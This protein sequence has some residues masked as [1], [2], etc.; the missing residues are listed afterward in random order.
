MV[1]SARVASV[2]D[3]RLKSF[4]E[5]VKGRRGDQKAIVAVANKMLKIIWFMLTRREEYQSTNRKMYAKK[6]Y[7]HGWQKAG[8]R[9]QPGGRLS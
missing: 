5:R 7:G 8:S 1:E 4:Y 3:P 2:H 6:Q 9:K